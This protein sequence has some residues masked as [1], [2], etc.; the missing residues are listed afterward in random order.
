MDCT[1]L[2]IKVVPNANANEVIG[3]EEDYLKIRLRAVPE[4]GKANKALIAFLA[5]WLKISKSSITLTKG[6]TSRLKVLKIE[7]SKQKLMKVIEDQ[8]S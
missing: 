5:D 3:W 2:R 6:E 7:L 1:E 4:K 8:L